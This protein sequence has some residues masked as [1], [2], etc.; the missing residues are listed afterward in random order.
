MKLYK[1]KLVESD[2]GRERTVSTEAL[3]M[4]EAI[5]TAYVSANHWLGENS[6]TWQ[7]VSAEDRTYAH[8]QQKKKALSR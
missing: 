7:I 1:F 6:K 8:E 5:S 4:Q 2:T 3:S